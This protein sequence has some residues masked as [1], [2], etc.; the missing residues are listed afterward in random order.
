MGG[1]LVVVVGMCFCG[2]R[3]RGSLGVAELV[4]Y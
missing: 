4:A 2:G 1:S 3:V